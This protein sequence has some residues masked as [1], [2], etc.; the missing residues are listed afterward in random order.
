MHAGGLPC[1]VSHQPLGFGRRDIHLEGGG[2]KARAPGAQGKHA[3][4]GG[5]AAHMDECTLPPN[6][7]AKQ[8]P[9]DYRSLR[10][11]T[12]APFA[13]VF[14]GSVARRISESGTGKPDS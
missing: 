14:K 9:R 4:S 12:R 3:I 13:A 1:L 11:A 2:P 6:L 5:H 8:V 7:S 10:A